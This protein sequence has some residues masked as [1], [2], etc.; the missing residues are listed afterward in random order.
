[1]S[2]PILGKVDVELNID[3]LI[4]YQ[5]LTVLENLTFNI[6]LGIDFLKA[7]KAHIN[8]EN[9]TLAIQ[10]NLLNV[11]LNNIETMNE[12]YAHVKTIAVEVIPPHCEMIIPVRLSVR[13]RNNSTVIL[14]PNF[15]NDIKNLVGSKVVVNVQNG[16]ALYR[17]LNPTGLSIKLYRNKKIA[18]AFEIDKNGIFASNDNDSIYKSIKVNKYQNVEKELGIKI[19]ENLNADQRKQ[20]T[21]LLS[22]NRNVFAKDITELGKTSYHYHR[23][24]TGN[25]PP[26]QSMPYRQTPQMRQETEKHIDIMLK[27]DIIEES[28]SPWSSPIVL[29]RKKK[30][31][32]DAKQEYRFAV[33]Y[34]RLNKCTLKGQNLVFPR[35]DDVFDTVANSKAV[36]YSVLDLMSGFFQTPLDPETKHKSAFVTH[37]API[38]VF[39]DFEKPFVLSVDASDYAIGY[40]LGQLNPNTKLEHVVA[41]GGR[42]LN[43]NEQK[44]HI[45]EKE[46]PGKKNNADALSR[47]EYE[48]IGPENFPQNEIEQTV[49]AMS[50]KKY[51]IIT[52]D[53]KGD[54]EQ[55]PNILT[56]TDNGNEDDETL[57]NIDPEQFKKRKTFRHL[58]RHCPD[59]VEIFNYKLDGQVPEE[60][61]KAR[62]LDAKAFHYEIDNGILYHFFNA[63]S[64]SLP[65]GQNMVK[66]LAIPRTLRKEVLEAFH[67]N[68]VGCHQGEERTYEAV[69]QR[70]YW[71][72]MYTDIKTYIKTCE[73]CQ[74]SKRNTHSHPLPLKPMPI[75]EVFSRWHMDILE[76]PE[77]PEKYRYLLLVVDSGSK[78][79]EAFPMRTQEATEVANILFREIIA[80]FGAPRCIV[81]DQGANFLSKLVA[82]LCEL[83]QIKRHYTSAYH[84]QT[85]AACERM[86]SFIVQSLRAQLEKQTDWPNYIAPIMMAYRMTPATQS[87]Q[88]SPFHLL[89]GQEMR[90]PIDVALIPKSTLPKNHR[91]YL[92]KFIKDLLLTR[93]VAAENTKRA[94]AKY[95]TQHDKRAVKPTYLPGDKV[96]LFCKKVKKGQSPKL[97]VRWTGPFTITNL[98]PRLKTDRPD[99][100]LDDTDDPFEEDEDDEENK[101]NTNKTAQQATTEIQITPDDVEKIISSAWVNKKLCY[102][103]KIKNMSKTEWVHQDKI[104]ENMRREFHENRTHTGKKRKR[105]LLGN[106]HKFFEPSNEPQN[107]TA[108]DQNND[109]KYKQRPKIN[110]DKFPVQA[111]KLENNRFSVKTILRNNRISHY[112]PLHRVNGEDQHAFTNLLDYFYG[113]QFYNIMLTL[114]GNSQTKDMGPACFVTGSHITHFKIENNVPKCFIHYEEKHIYDPEWVPFET[115]PP[116]LLKIF[117]INM[118]MSG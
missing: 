57:E 89:F 42:S 61:Q 82:A 26:V 65:K 38:L 72:N 86:N 77:T 12:H 92:N 66:Q 64:R 1:M 59:F 25:A 87:T 13:H 114:T 108:I 36:I 5:E 8:F 52:F 35:I 4:I 112:Q 74:R 104:P 100:L 41:Y 97:K 7:N 81:S 34:R 14:E 107:V 85:N 105:P 55:Q 109:V 111:V 75:E 103:I 95:K 49:A 54:D 3:D 50:N 70:Y 24:D 21:E 2:Y 45:N 68:I 83:L 56:I 80:R 28:N 15:S 53:Y 19:N 88:Y 106:K 93:D 46:G 63:R 47:R 99:Y 98:G 39:P 29:V 37:Q 90:A 31:N 91:E 60:R 110:W 58:Q 16:K 84:P 18:K 78:W 17:I 69:R 73:I 79:C 102:K 43:K 20:L 23:I 115:C 76:L 118:K 116:G 113:D 94:Q 33:D 71:P 10:E 67:D 44:W 40:V 30:S 62:Q 11:P 48:K 22:R 96:M 9:N 51:E 32:M 27:N 117:K 6:I 101:Q